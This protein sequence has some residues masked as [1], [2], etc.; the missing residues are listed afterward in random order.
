ME[1]AG[2]LLKEAIEDVQDQL[3]MLGIVNGT[4][5]VGG[6]VSINMTMMGKMVYLPT[7]QVNVH[8]FGSEANMII[9]RHPIQ[10][11]M[12]F[13]MSPLWSRS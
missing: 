1:E 3:Y 10:E 8:M 4:V 11:T 6:E 12:A 7:Y 5:K 9:L 13:N 2:A